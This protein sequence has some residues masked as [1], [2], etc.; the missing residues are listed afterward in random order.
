MPKRRE[1][2]RII[3]KYI[4]TA[5]CARAAGRHSTWYFDARDPADPD[6]VYQVRQ[7]AYVEG[8]VEVIGARDVAARMLSLIR[9]AQVDA[10]VE[11]ETRRRAAENEA[12]LQAEAI[13]HA[14]EERG[15]VPSSVTRD[16]VTLTHAQLFDLLGGT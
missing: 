3:D 8:V 7:S 16:E 5:R 14:L 2:K 11:Y 13:Y 9:T 4:V 1:L 12:A 15:I 6:V 10:S